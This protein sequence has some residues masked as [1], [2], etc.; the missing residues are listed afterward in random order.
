PEPGPADQREKAVGTAQPTSGATL[1]GIMPLDVQLVL[2]PGIGPNDQVRIRPNFDDFS[3]QSFVALAWPVD[4]ALRGSPRNPT[5]PNTLLGAGNAYASVWSSYRDANDLYP[6]AKPDR[7][8]PFDAPATSGCGSGAGLVLV[9][10]SKMGD[11]LSDTQQAFSLPLVDQS[12]NYVY[13]QMLFNRDQYDFVRGSDSDPTTWL[14]RKTALFNA[15]KV[16]PIGMPQA[17]ADTKV[18]GAMMLKAAWKQLTKQDDASRYYT[19]QA[20]IQDPATGKCGA[21]TTVGL[22][23]LHIAHKLSDFPQWVWSS[24][25]HVDNVPPASGPAPRRMTLNNG[26]NIPPVNGDGFANAPASSTPVQDP[27]PVQV[28]R[29]NPIPTTP[30]K[31][32]GQQYPSGAGSTADLNAAYQALL[33]GSVW[34]NYQLVITQWPFNAVPQN[35][36]K[37]PEKQ[38]VYPGDAG[39]AFPLYGAVNTSMETYFQTQRAALGAGGNSCM[40]CHYQAGM[41]DFSWS[42]KLRSQNPKT[43][44]QQRG[45]P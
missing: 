30:A 31:V 13:Y 8:V 40:Q 41:T 10:N 20:Q 37:P 9:K 21:P 44:A 28:V 24:F 27:I 23:G 35:R 32:S 36:F 15:E 16:A 17:N 33:K 19:R 43:T 3:W 39:G 22:I 5:D 45:R 4:P 1:S 2:N 6:G 29:M 42:L 26:T 11:P 7:P 14:Y 34:A 18:Q 25:E 12:R 38:G